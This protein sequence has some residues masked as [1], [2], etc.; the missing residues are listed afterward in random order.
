MKLSLLADYKQSTAERI[1]VSFV[2][3]QVE[4]GPFKWKKVLL[5]CRNSKNPTVSNLKDQRYLL[6][7]LVILRTTEVLVRQIIFVFEV[8]MLDLCSPYCAIPSLSQQGV[9]C[10][11]PELEC[12]PQS[13]RLLSFHLWPYG[14]YITLQSG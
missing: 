3:L 13:C 14:L 2:Y 7:Q 5:P 6:M 12:F 8:V 4:A 11:L 10:C 9:L 1:D